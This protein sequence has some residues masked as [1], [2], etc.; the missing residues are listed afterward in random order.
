MKEAG[1]ARISIFRNTII[2]QCCFIVV[3]LLPSSAT[4]SGVS[5]GDFKFEFF[6]VATF[7]AL[8]G[9]FCIWLGYKLF[10]QGIQKGKSQLDFKSKF[11]SLVFSGVGPGLFFMAFG[12]LIVLVAVIV[13]AVASF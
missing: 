9:A 2:S 4:A 7:G 12:A 1:M 6:G 8:V 11:F 10:T 13:A 5:F 3:A